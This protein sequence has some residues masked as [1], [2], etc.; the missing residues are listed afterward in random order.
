MSASF[1]L[2]VD[3]PGW[4]DV[5][6]FQLAGVACDIRETGDPR[7]DLALLFSEKPAVAAGVFTTNDIKAAPVRYDQQILQTGDRFSAI[8]VNSGNAN[9]CTGA[10]GMA[11]TEAMAAQAAQLL[12]VDP[13]QVFVCSTG[14]IGRALPMEKVAAGISDAADD[15]SA[16]STQSLN[17]AW[18]I[19]TSDTRPKTVTSTFEID[20]Q[21]VT[22]AGMGKGAGMI[23]PNMATML[24]FIATDAA[25]SKEALQSHL[26][27]ANTNTFNAITVDGDM[28]TNDTVLA[29]ANSLSGISV[30][31]FSSAAGQAFQAAL[32][33]V[34]QCLAEKI[35]ADGERVT[36]QVTINISGAPDD[37]S[38]EK[39][40]RAIGNSLLVKTSWYGNDPNWGRV[41]DA[42]GYARV[43][44]IE[45][46]LD[47]H[48]DEVPAILAGT[49][50]HE[51]LPQWRE[52]VARES[53]CLNLNLNLGSGHYQLLCADLSEGYVAFNKSE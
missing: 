3:S 40:A 34:C 31:D 27:A 1:Q 32:Q 37:L 29:L 20:G 7:L 16:D 51:N 36:K 44:I 9:A 10:Q 49:P 26:E 38:A 17:A 48:Y 45:D 35:V 50:Q 5:P 13:A 28:S 8:V 43:G 47:M 19:L 14:R 41:L 53:F 2:Q 33:A 22:I 24:A 52:V 12:E 11:D 46:H 6:G 21:T 23:E 30:D 25:V 4:S 39:V 15:L 18:A 42:A